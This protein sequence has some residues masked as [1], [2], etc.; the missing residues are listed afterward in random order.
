MENMKKSFRFLELNK[1]RELSRLANEYNIDINAQRDSIVVDCKSFMGLI[2]ICSDKPITI[3]PITDNYE[4]AQEIL[5]KIQK[6]VEE[7]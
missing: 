4:L 2:E 5:N 1:I 6:I 7:R 3:T